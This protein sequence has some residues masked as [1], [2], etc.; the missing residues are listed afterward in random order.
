M[1]RQET[2]APNKGQSRLPQS[3][4]AGCTF[5]MRATT[6]ILLL[7]MLGCLSPLAL[8]SVCF[9]VKL[10]QKNQTFRAMCVYPCSREGGVNLHKQAPRQAGVPGGLQAPLA[11]L[12][13]PS[14]RQRHSAGQ[15]QRPST[16]PPGQ[17]G[18]ALRVVQAP[19]DA[20][21]PQE[22]L[23]HQEGHHRPPAAYPRPATSSSPHPSSPKNV[24]RRELCPRSLVVRMPAPSSPSRPSEALPSYM[25]ALHMAGRWQ[26]EAELPSYNKA[27]NM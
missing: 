9:L 27:I 1:A 10:V 26:E 22:H 16:Q 6:Y 4:P 8:F 13:S 15:L 25:E 3:P 20:W 11:I 21:L 12:P 18:R 19:G 2:Q 24:L 5:L 14:A 7:V 17:A 23:G